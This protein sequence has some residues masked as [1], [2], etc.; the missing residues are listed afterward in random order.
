MLDGYTHRDRIIKAALKLAET[1]GWRDL[2]LGEIAAEA[3]IP[4]I[5][6]R[7]EFQGKSQILAAFVRAVDLAVLEKFPAPGPDVARDRLFDVLL[8]RFEVMQPYKPAIRRISEDATPGEALQQLRPA[9]KSQYWMLAA[10]GLSGEGGT[11][12]VRVQGLLG[13]YGRVFQVWVDDDDPG[14]AK[15]MAALDKRL[16]RGE[17]IM[18]GFERFRDGAES[19]LRGFGRRRK[20]TAEPQPEPAPTPDAGISPAAPP[21]TA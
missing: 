2:S 7:K 21:Q 13:I 5:E 8:T 15:T 18:H 6:F 14:L 9:L 10:A 11:G 4:L 12:L 17:S 16:R 3:Q 1:S 19:L 20:G